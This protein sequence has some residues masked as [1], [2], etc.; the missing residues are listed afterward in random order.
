MFWAAGNFRPQ[1]E[2]PRESRMH[3]KQRALEHLPTTSE[4]MARKRRMNLEKKKKR[5][6]KWKQ[7]LCLGRTVNRM[8]FSC[9]LPEKHPE[10]KWTLSFSL[11]Y[12]RVKLNILHFKST[13]RNLIKTK[14]SP[15]LK[16]IQ[17]FCDKPAALEQL[18]RGGSFALW[19]APGI[20]VHQETE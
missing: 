15:I 13:W 18:S 17:T 16:E 10:W 1:R 11:H 14:R 2:T 9:A 3:R 12:Q 4:A 8:Q 7:M 19:G 20:L 6:S 5:K